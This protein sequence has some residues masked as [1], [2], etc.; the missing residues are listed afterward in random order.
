MHRELDI[1]A[2]KRLEAHHGASRHKLG[3]NF[4]RHLCRPL[5]ALGGEDGRG[6]RADALAGD[7]I[8]EFALHTIGLA[9]PEARIG[10]RIDKRHGLSRRTC[11]PIA[12]RACERGAK[13]RY[14]DALALVCKILM[15]GDDAAI[16]QQLLEGHD[17]A[18]ANN[19]GVECELELDGAIRSLDHNLL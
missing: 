4:E 2:Q 5:G 19:S 10:N 7:L 14:R 18:S 3:G 6:R 16:A 8:D 15:L 9:W 12:L 13:A 17:A 1:V 11:D